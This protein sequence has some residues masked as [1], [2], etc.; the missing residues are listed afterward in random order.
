MGLFIS[1]RDFWLTLEY[2]WSIG[3][4]NSQNNWVW[5]LKKY[6]FKGDACDKP[7]NWNQ[8]TPI[9]SQ[10][11]FDS[12]EPGSWVG[13]MAPKKQVTQTLASD[14]QLFFSCYITLISGNR[15]LAALYEPSKAVESCGGV[16]TWR[17]LYPKKVKCKQYI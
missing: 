4:S 17:K 11:H 5:C 8:G 6:S 9:F 13:V 16:P 12:D 10:T 15:V 1:I 14:F 7:S 2:I 3:I